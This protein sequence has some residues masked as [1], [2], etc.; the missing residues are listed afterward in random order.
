MDSNI[1][2][3]QM[4]MPVLVKQNILRLQITMDD[5]VGME[6]GNSTRTFRNDKLYRLL[7]QRL[8]LIK[9][10]SQIPSK[11]QVDHHK[12]VFLILESVS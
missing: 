6:I 8:I 4:R 9:L 5:L 10:V 3:S 11:H 7:C 1:E 12:H 2:I